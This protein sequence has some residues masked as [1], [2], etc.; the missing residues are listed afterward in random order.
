MFL[1]PRAMIRVAYMSLETTCLAFEGNRLRERQWDRPQPQP[2][3]LS[4]H[5][6]QSRSP[7]RSLE[8]VRVRAQTVDYITYTLTSF[9]PLEGAGRVSREC[10]WRA[11]DLS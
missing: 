1:N 11:M 6:H 3:V 2:E 10:G 8:C 4:S 5:G 9:L 7:H